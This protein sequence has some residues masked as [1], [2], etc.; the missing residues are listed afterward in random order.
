VPISPVRPVRILRSTLPEA[1]NSKKEEIFEG[2]IQKTGMKRKSSSESYESSSP[3]R[4]T[5][6]KAVIAKSSNE[7]LSSTLDSLENLE[8]GSTYLHTKEERDSEIVGH[9]NEQEETVSA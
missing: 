5:R 9:S 1:I 2:N 3:S 4:M 7:S 6:S 8:S